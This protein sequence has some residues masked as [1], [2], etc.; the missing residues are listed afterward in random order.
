M[1]H[2]I[3]PSKDDIYVI[4][5]ITGLISQFNLPGGPTHPNE[6]VKELNLLYTK[7]RSEL[8]DYINKINY[9]KLRQESN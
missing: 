4:Y 5:F 6:V 7:S 9:Q 8:L 2:A 1:E 3:Q